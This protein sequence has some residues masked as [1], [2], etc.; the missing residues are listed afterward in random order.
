MDKKQE[1]VGRFLRTMLHVLPDE[2]VSMLEVDPI[3]RSRMDLLYEEV[4]E[5]LDAI[6][7]RDL[8][9]IGGEGCDVIYSVYAIAEAHGLDLDP[10]WKRIQEANMQK[11]PNPDGKPIKG[12]DWE[13]PDL[14]AALREAKEGTHSVPFVPSWAKH[15]NEVLDA[16]AGVIPPLAMADLR[17]AI[18]ME[19]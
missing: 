17:R 15:L 2:P 18:I 16:Y 9:Q 3:A 6:H 5:F 13:K 11:L 8:A 12:S 1:D 4:A 19:S 7:S 10:F 14:K